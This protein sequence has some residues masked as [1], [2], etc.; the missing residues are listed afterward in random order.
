MQSVNLIKIFKTFKKTEIKNFRK[1]IKSP[2]FNTSA[3]TSQLFL[4]LLDDGFKYRN[5][6]PDK[7]KLFALIYN[8]KKYSDAVMRKLFSNLNK[9]CEDYLAVIR[10]VNNKYEMKR[11]L[12]FELRDRNTAGNYRQQIKSA[13]KWLVGRQMNDELYLEKFY[14]DGVYSLLESY[15][16]NYSG[17]SNR[18]QVKSLLNFF[19]IS[20]AKIASI[21]FILR[22]IFNTEIKNPLWSELE[23]LKLTGWFDTE[24]SVAVFIDIARLFTLPL[25]EA[26]ELLDK[27][28]KFDF[29][30]HLHIDDRSLAYYIITQF[31]IVI[32][33]KD[34][35]PE[36]AEMKWKYIKKHVEI[37]VTSG[38]TYGTDFFIS[39]ITNGLARKDIEWVK[40]FKEKMSKNLISNDKEAF[41]KCIDA[42]ILRA[43][44]KFSQSLDVLAK[45]T[46][47][48]K[49]VKDDVRVLTIINLFELKR[50]EDIYV[51]LNTYRKF[52]KYSEEKISKI[53]YDLDLGF[54]KATDLLL[55]FMFS[56]SEPEKEKIEFSLSRLFEKRF[57]QRVWIMEKFNILRKDVN[58]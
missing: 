40:Q 24:K 39:V 21:N 7:H 53:D 25:N 5:N 2:F 42:R 38:N 36:Y 23:K 51:I 13:D 35:L 49:M 30:A 8:N 50:Y 6:E 41:L 18:Q 57:L 17:N 4:L 29:E 11:K 19:G 44:N 3:A 58:N 22:V 10:T 1:F 37:I 46:P 26:K 15:E 43:E 9:L 34:N 31:L 56:S 28:D 55:K 32:S 47:K 33:K 52:L 48:T 12:L 16:N 54:I 20:Y 14:I 27:I 45:I